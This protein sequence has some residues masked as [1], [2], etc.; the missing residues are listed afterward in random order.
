M[1]GGWK[2]ESKL[3]RLPSMKIPPVKFQPCE[4]SK[5]IQSLKL[6]MACSIDG[7]PN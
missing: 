3:C 5:E 7:I 4:V 6:G 1:N 2:L